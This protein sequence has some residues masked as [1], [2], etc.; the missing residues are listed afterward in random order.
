MLMMSIGKQMKSSAP[1]FFEMLLLSSTH[2][3]H[4]APDR[5]SL[6]DRPES[7]LFLVVGLED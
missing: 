1:L 7:D 5:A 6:E 4:A 3:S 2:I